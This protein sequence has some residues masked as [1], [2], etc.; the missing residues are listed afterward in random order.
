MI[1]NA[2]IVVEFKNTILESVEFIYTRYIWF[3]FNKFRSCQNDMCNKIFLKL[4]TSQ[5]NKSGLENY[6]EVEVK[7]LHLY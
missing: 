2:L 5:T 3:F 1:E 4:K 7:L 6:L